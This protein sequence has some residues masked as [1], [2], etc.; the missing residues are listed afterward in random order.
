MQL[1]GAEGPS[2]FQVTYLDP[3]SCLHIAHLSCDPPSW[4][5]LFTSPILLSAVRALVEAAE[6]QS[7]WR[8]MECF[9]SMNFVD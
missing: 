7:E 9:W 3:L 4:T 5:C 1:R 6:Q 8:R 2:V